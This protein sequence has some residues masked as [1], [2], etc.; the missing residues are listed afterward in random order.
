MDW[1]EDE[2]L[3]ENFERKVGIN[4]NRNPFAS[5]FCKSVKDE[6]YTYGIQIHFSLYS[7]KFEVRIGRFNSKNANVEGFSHLESLDMR[8]KVTEV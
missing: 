6:G 2:L 4:K 8:L 7:Y 1:K 3:V 5:V